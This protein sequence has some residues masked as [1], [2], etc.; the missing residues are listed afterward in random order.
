MDPGTKR[1]FFGDENQRIHEMHTRRLVALSD[2]LKEADIRLFTA[3]LALKELLAAKDPPIRERKSTKLLTEFNKLELD[4]KYI[5][6]KNYR[7]T[8]FFSRRG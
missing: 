2:E 5:F 3:R 8:V 1:I 4:E 6:R 7:S